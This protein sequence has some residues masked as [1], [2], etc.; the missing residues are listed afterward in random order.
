MTEQLCFFDEPKKETKPEMLVPIQNTKDVIP[1]AE[2]LAF[3][4]SVR[5]KEST[6]DQYKAMPHSYTVREWTKDERSFERFLLHVRATGFKHHFFKKIYTYLLIDGWYYWT[7]GWP[8]DETT[9]IN[10]A[11]KL[12]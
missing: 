6:S 9:V 3:I 1:E 10:R 11:R 7:M 5:W 8:A 12:I 2:A 4:R